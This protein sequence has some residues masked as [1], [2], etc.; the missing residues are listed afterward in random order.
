MAEAPSQGEGWPRAL[1]LLV[2]AMMVAV[3]QPAVVMVVA[4]A[5][6]TFTGQG[7]R[8]LVLLFTAAAVALVFSGDPSGVLWYLERGWAVLIG[9]WFVSLTMLLPGRSFL[10]RAL[11]AV[12]GTV[13]SAL[14]ALV[15]IDGWGSVDSGM[16]RQIEAGLATTVEIMSSAIEGDLETELADTL[17]AASRIQGVLFPALLALSSLAALGVAWW[18]HVRMAQLP[19]PALRP[20]REFRFADPLI[21]VFISGLVLVVVAEWS[22]GWGRLGTNLLAFMG[23]LYMLRGAA[24][25]LVIWGSVSFATG[26]LFAVVVVLAGPVVA[27]GAMLVG[28]GDSW[29]DLRTR[30]TAEPGGGT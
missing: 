2:A 15:L 23:A 6:L 8:L 17:A 27:L 3:G 30:V 21:W 22:V 20:L 24:V 10:T 7:G 19:G 18:L 16:S 1:G 25:L 4:F 9:G 14:V 11:P 29:L 28:V 13:A 5:M 12:A 26:L